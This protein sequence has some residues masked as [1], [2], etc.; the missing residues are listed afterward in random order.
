MIETQQT[1]AAWARATFPGGDDL[2][3]RHVLRLL[4]E[5]VEACLAAGATWL[6]VIQTVR[7][8]RRPFQDWE[9]RLIVPAEEIAEELADCAIVLTVI[10]ARRGI[11]LQ[12]EVDAKMAVN[13]ARSWIS[14]G[15]GTGYHV[16][17]GP[18]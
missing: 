18:S 11:D 16:P 17:E 13:R 6:E 9:R 10:S 5:V 7:K 14:N 4:E 8:H 2:S 1:I 15:D 3:P 12:A